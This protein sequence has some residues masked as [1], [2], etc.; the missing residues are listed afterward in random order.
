MDVGSFW[1]P[2]ACC[3]KIARLAENRATAEL[4]AEHANH[5][6]FPK[7][8]SGRI[9]GAVQPGSEWRQWRQIVGLLDARA[10]PSVM[11]SACALDCNTP[12]KRKKFAAGASR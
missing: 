11:P 6:S 4:G 3:P 9:G 1:L 2:A 10:H 12:H 7:I 5:L 8:I